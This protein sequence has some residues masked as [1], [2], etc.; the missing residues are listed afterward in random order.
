MKKWNVLIQ[1]LK[2]A[3]ISVEI[4]TAETR[5]T[6]MQLAESSHDGWKAKDAVEAI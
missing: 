1:E 6:A 5:F 3:H 2:T 4:I